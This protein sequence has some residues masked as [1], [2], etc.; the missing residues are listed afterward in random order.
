M[1]KI[2]DVALSNKTIIFLTDDGSLY[3]ATFQPEKII[4]GI[5]KPQRMSFQD[6]LHN[7]KVVE[8]F[9]SNEDIFFVL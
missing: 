3:S 1:V 6:N 7:Q 8:L 4:K 5:W 9:T 2:I